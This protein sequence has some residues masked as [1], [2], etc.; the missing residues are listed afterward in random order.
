[1]SPRSAGWLAI[2]GALILGVL[3]GVLIARPPWSIPGALVLVGASI[4]FSVGAVWLLRRSWSQAWP[5][6]TKPTVQKQLRRLRVL[7]IISSVLCVALVAATA[8][9]IV[10][11]NW[12]QLL[13]AGLLA[14][15]AINN[16]NIY[17]RLLRSVRKI[18][19]NETG[20]TPKQ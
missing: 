13:Y 17:R 10:S 12:W 1:M 7:H 8:F 20:S 18:Q 6:Y 19:S 16:L 3:G 4:L 15:M 11:Q 2:I 14:V 5:P 9:S